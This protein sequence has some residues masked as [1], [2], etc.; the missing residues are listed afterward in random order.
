[1]SRVHAGR[2]EDA[3]RQDRGR[4]AHLTYT[5]VHRSSSKD[6][7]PSQLLYLHATAPNW[8]PESFEL[9]KTWLQAALANRAQNPGPFGEARR[10]QHERHYTSKPLKPEDIAK[11]RPEVMKSFYTARFVNAADLTFFF[12]GSFTIE[13][14]TPLL[15]QYIASLPSTGAP[16]SKLVDLKLQFPSEV[17][18]ETVR[19][20]QEPKSQTVISFFADTGLDEMEM[21]RLRSAASVLE[22]R[23][24]DIIRE[25]MGGPRRH[26]GYVDTQ[27]VKGYGLVQVVFGSSPDNVDK[28]V[29]AVMKEIARLKAEGPADDDIQKVKEIEKRTLETSARNNGYWLNS[30][31][32]VQSLGWDLLSIARRPQRTESLSKENVQ[33]AFRKYFPEGRHTIVTLLPEKK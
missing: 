18:K 12:T 20:G 17:K 7:R 23:L 29:D 27:P 25:E 8:T 9:L 21:H 26:V 16:T 10:D 28:L 3:R 15:T 32:T 14:I 31:Q 13:Q 1:M 19:K 30:M 5:G 24:T 2:Q 6:L 4:V 11:L 22:M 33:A